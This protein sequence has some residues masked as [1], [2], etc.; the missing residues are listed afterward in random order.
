MRWFA[1]AI[2]IVVLLGITACEKEKFNQNVYN[3]VVDYMFMVDNMDRNHD[4]CLTHSDTV[5]LYTRSEDIYSVQVLTNNPYLSEQAEIAAQG[6]CFLNSS[7]TM[8]SATL[9]F[10]VPLT[11][12][13]VYLATKDKAGNYLGITPFVFGTDSIDLDKQV[14]QHGII[15]EPK[16][17]TFTYLYEEGFPLPG[18]FDFNDLVL[19]I[20]KIYTD[21][22]YQ[23][24]LQVSIDAVGASKSY[25]A[26][27]QLVGVSYDDIES[28][29]ILEGK[30]MDAGYTL[31]RMTIA[32]D[33]TLLRGR[34][35]EAV[36]NLF[37]SGHWAVNPKLNSV[38][39]VQTLFYNTEREDRENYSAT[40]PPVTRT[41]RV[42]FK[43]RAVA[44]DVSFDMIDPFIV[45]EYNGGLWEIHTY[46]YKFDETL[47]SIYNGKASFYDN[48][49][50]WALVVPQRDFRYPIERMS[51]GTFN[52]ELGETF[53]PYTSFADWMK[54]HTANNDW[55]LNIRYPQLLY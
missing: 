48:H 53:G 50:S 16:L 35:G 46:R 30:P 47:N 28:V 13:Q 5:T 14:Y 32:S 36:I 26:A 24:D 38:G 55:Y 42:N 6:T 1:A 23:L 18:D 52:S 43:S 39:N 9:A 44:R 51:L 4:W 25:A 20:S 7:K 34:H 31:R 10:T 54:D 8:F 21:L 37:E 19:R 22:S 40:V 33:K 17:Q 11:Q 12:T 41:Y 15:N 45:Q 29:T 3:Q 27:L 2:S 49:V